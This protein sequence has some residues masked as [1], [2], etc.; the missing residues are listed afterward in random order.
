QV[1]ARNS[2]SGIANGSPDDVE[3]V[4]GPVE[5]TN[6]TSRGTLKISERVGNQ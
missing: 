4:S 1:G 3:A 5:L 2:T 6:E